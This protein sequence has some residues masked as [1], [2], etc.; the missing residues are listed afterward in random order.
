MELTVNQRI[1]LSTVIE[2]GYYEHYVLQLSDNN[3][4][5]SKKVSFNLCN[6]IC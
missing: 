5:V 1:Y 6:I 2:S 3:A 4:Q